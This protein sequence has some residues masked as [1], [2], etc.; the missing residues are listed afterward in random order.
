MSSLLCF[1]KEFDLQLPAGGSGRRPKVDNSSFWEI[2]FL[3]IP[4]I[5]SQENG[6]PENLVGGVLLGLN[7]ELSSGKV[8]DPAEELDENDGDEDGEEL[9]LREEGRNKGVEYGVA[10]ASIC[11]IWAWLALL[12][13]ASVEAIAFLR[14]KRSG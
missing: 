9:V 2:S 3:G 13:A 11:S 1:L 4:G 8:N 7:G 5:C 10:S 6:I 12:Y 14:K